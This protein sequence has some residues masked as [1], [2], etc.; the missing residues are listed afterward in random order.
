MLYVFYELRE[1]SWPADVWDL[2][3]IYQIDIELYYKGVEVICMGTQRICN[4]VKLVLESSDAA[5]IRWK[6]MFNELFVI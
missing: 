2:R 4:K 5:W 6:R 3:K 1:T